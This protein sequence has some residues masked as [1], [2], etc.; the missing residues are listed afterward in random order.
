MES[1]REFLERVSKVKCGYG[2]DM[3][4]II[5]LQEA[6]DAAI[7]KECSDRAQAWQQKLCGTNDWSCK[8]CTGCDPLRAA[9]EGKP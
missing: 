5:D 4:T 9:I 2:W 6:R 3:N 8:G 1:A 7:R